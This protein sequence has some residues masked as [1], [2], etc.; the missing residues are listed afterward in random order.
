QFS[1]MPLAPATPLGAG[2]S[3]RVEVAARPGG[4]GP[5]QAD[6]VITLTEELIPGRQL[7]VPLTATGVVANLGYGPAAID[8]GMR[9]VG[10][11]GRCRSA[12]E[13]RNLGAQAVEGLTVTATLGDFRVEAV[14]AII[15]PQQAAM[16]PISF[17]PLLSGDRRGMLV[18]RAPGLLGMHQVAV[19]G[20]GLG[21]SL[22]L[23][24]QTLQFGAVEIGTEPPP[25]RQLL[26]VNQGNYP[27]EAEVVLEPPA[28]EEFAIEPTALTL[29]P[30]Q[31]QAIQI[32]FAPKQEGDRALLLHL[33]H[34][35]GGGLIESVEIE[36]RAYIRPQ[37]P[38]S[39]GCS[40]A[41]RAQAC[42]FPIWGLGLALLLLLRPTPVLC[43]RRT[44]PAQ[45]AQTGAPQ[46]VPG[47]PPFCPTHQDTIP[48]SA[49]RGP[50]GPLPLAGLV[51]ARRQQPARA[52]TV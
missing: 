25:V 15:P 23:S 35:E 12:L 39:A 4:G 14:P 16:L 37:P 26:V 52:G 27:L 22:Q 51:L 32:R 1:L 28:P 13:V 3:L 10:T 2:A 18:L 31:P 7:R 21:I 43:P 11:S 34:R 45:G 42:P 41:A 47:R 6:L 33:Q 17:R 5:R 24:P 36:A 8:C 48:A 49:G 9:P 29:L 19:S 38:S 30:Q 44:G 40:V 50:G 46:A 20:T